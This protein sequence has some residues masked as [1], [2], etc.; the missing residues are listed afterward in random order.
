MSHTED[1]PGEDSDE[2]PSGDGSEHS[3]PRY[4]FAVDTDNADDILPL[5][6]DLSADV[7]ADLYI[8]SLV[9]LPDQTPLEMPEPR[10]QGQRRA[11]EFVLAAKQQ[12]HDTSSIEQ[13]VKTGHNRKS[14]LQDFV[15]TYDISTLITEDH[16]RSGIRT[17][18][19]LESVDETA[20]D[21]CDTIIVTRIEQLRTID[22]VVVPVAR[23]PHSGMAI[24]VGLAIARQNDA[25]LDLLHVYDTSDEEGRTEGEEVLEI[26]MERV[27]NYPDADRTLREASNVPDEIIR[28]TQPYDLTVLGAPREG[29][30]RQFILGTIPDDVSAQAEGTVLTA[31]REGADE[32]WLDRLI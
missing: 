8:G 32:S 5:V 14:I 2:K 25:T 22:S 19:G 4:L 29:R 30:L 20:V 18:L 15:D 16:P 13:V 9:T 7:G 23:G 1:G 21:G 24:D 12:C 3:Q 6:C 11:A 17:I 10:Q 27:R 26:G 31:H 28:Y